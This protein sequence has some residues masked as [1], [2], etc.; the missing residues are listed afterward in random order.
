MQEARFKRGELSGKGMSLTVLDR[1]TATNGIILMSE[2]E[3]LLNI[4]RA[5]LIAVM[6][7]AGTRSWARI[8][9]L[10]LRR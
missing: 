8:W 2:R 9:A 6:R 7:N 5:F 3:K 10:Q 1:V 4:S